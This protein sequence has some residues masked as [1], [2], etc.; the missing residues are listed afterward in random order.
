[1]WNNRHGDFQHDSMT[2]AS[3]RLEENRPKNIAYE[4]KKKLDIK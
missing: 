1:M 4:K 3:H 2:C